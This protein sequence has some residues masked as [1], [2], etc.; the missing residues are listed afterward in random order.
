MI[1]TFYSYKGGTGRTMA[2]ANIAWLLASR[3]KK[4]LAV[5]FDLEAP[6]LWRYFSRFH[7]G[8]QQEKG[9]IDLLLAASSAEDFADINWKE[10][11]T[12]VSFQQVSLSLMTSGQAGDEYPSRVLNFDWATFFRDSRG[13]EFIESMRTR[14]KQEYD[15]TLIDSRTGITDTGGICT[16]LLPDMIIPVFVSNRQSLEGVVDVIKRAQ[17]GRNELAYDR[18]PAAILPILSRFDSRTEWESAQ[19][20]LDIAAAHLKPFYADWLPK[21]FE[22]RHV[23]E[24]TKLPYVA[25]FSFG[26]TLPALA[27]GISDPESLGYALNT[28]S[29]LIESELGNAEFIMGG[30]SP[31]IEL[32]GT[33]QQEQ[34][35]ASV[36]G[37]GTGYP[38]IEPAQ[39][40]V[41]LAP[42]P[43]FLVGREELLAELD[44]RLNG[45]SQAGPGV[46]ALVGLGGVG[47]T[48][49][50][51]EYAH[52]QLDQLDV[53]WQLSAEEPAGLA[54]GFGE[55]AAR[56]GGRDGLGPGD[57]VAVVH[58]ALARR[59][60]WLLVFD[61]VPGPA[62]IQGMLPPA[63]GGRV[64]ITSQY[65]HWP[66]AQAVEVSVLD[67]AVAA[68]F[69]LARTGAASGEEQAAD[70]LAGELGGLP[71]ALEQAAAYMQA[72]GRDIIE[73]LGLFRARRAELLGRGEVAGYDKRVTTIWALAFSELGQADPAAGLLRLAA[74]CAA[75]DIPLDLLLR[76]V[77]GLNIERFGA[78]VAPLLGPLLE[79]ELVRDEAVA[80]L[81]RYSL[82]NA[83]HDGRVSVHRL[84]QA[85]TL[86][87]LPYEVAEAWRRAAAA[88]IEA[89][90]PGD[91][92]DPAAWPA[93]AALLP[94]AQA[95]LPLASDGMFKVAQYL[96]IIGN[97]TAAR[98]LLQ[99]L[100]QARETELGTEH[101]GTL[102]ARAELAYWTGEAGDAARARDQFAALLPIRERV[103]GTEHPRT[104][105]ARANLA[106][107]TGHAGDAAAARDQFAALLPVEERIFGPEHPETLIARASLARWT[108]YAG[109][110]AA[111]RDQFA[112]LLPVYERVL[113]AEHPDTLTTRSNL[114]SLT[115][116][117]GDAAAARDRFAALLPV[118]ERV[119]GAEH[120]RTL[121]TRANLASF[122]G[123]AGD[124]PAARDQF[125]VL[126]PVYERT[127]GTEHPSTLNARA[128]LAHWTRLTV[129]RT[130]Q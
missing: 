79:D 49:V 32:D 65:P 130:G 17:A 23:L 106:R 33:G 64:M 66:F 6:G 95:A 59:D 126:L 51:V 62:V 96:G 88:M 128:N 55:L 82:I 15:F 124:A 113:G 84:V 118:Y 13:G 129:E 76:P 71:L 3:G 122:T 35:M 1:I 45:R 75:E 94:H 22:P 97:Y 16:I 127:L 72:S 117:A 104:L 27:Q 60:D 99:Q 81:R 110:V 83:P 29:Q 30:P 40:A 31:V 4:V 89:A 68:A 57:P 77:P 50:A 11:V 86:A 25:Y 43:V 103:L 93:Y 21:Q 107:W 61:N 91:P 111:A 115:G 119:L 102:A 38:D 47:K 116:E 67:R 20:W 10:Y 28:I 53:V 46:V 123:Y 125:A 24:R 80:T 92:Q 85:I 12:E 74:C 8:L 42:R 18:P 108:G 69:L 56:L 39:V 73:Y 114:A 98:D 54:A 19:E 26:E 101:S 34:A 14:W 44:A 100:L 105:T 63:G 41:R 48:S 87:Q 2:V 70:E 5:D 121:S 37:W 112:A 36:P 9:L 120:P 78:E 90:L 52:R 109:D 58:A 7:K